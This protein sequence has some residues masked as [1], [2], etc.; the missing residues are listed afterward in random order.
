L[1][2]VAVESL[3]AERVQLDVLEPS[4]LDAFTWLH[5]FDQVTEYLSPPRPLTR[6]ESFRVFCQMLGHAQV[7]GFG[8]WAVRRLLD[9]E[10]LG[11]VGLWCPEGWPG[12]ELGWR[13]A[14]DHWGRGYAAEASRAVRDFAH[15]RLGHEELLSIIHANNHRSL[16][17]ARR[18]DMTRWQDRVIGGVPVNIYRWHAPANT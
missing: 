10:W 18:L 7:K 9:G 15:R 16:R 1:S 12:V 6:A 8:Y 13:F 17:L 14:P 5:T 2:H 3:I 4:D 11:I